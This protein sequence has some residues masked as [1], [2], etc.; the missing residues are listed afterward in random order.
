MAQTRYQRNAEKGGLGAGVTGLAV[1]MLLFSSYGAAGARAQQRGNMD[2]ELKR[3]NVDTALVVVSQD[4]DEF[5][6]WSPHGDFIAVQINGQW[7]KVE[8]G[9][10]A[11]QE[12][13]WRGSARLGVPSTPTQ[14]PAPAGEIQLWK[15]TSK[16]RPRRMVTRSGLTIELRETDLGTSLRLARRGKKP[17]VIWTT[18]LENCHSLALSPDERY[19]AFLCELNGLA[20][21]KLDG[22]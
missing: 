3:L 13:K 6:V 1:W 12:A 16:W 20:V 22:R 17:E 11:L 7:N 19:V 9:M 15:R 2:S 8:L 14:V 21:M 18:D 5:P 10:L 4:I